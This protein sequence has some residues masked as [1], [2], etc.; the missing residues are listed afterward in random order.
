MIDVSYV[1]EVIFV[2]MS[3]FKFSDSKFLVC[4]FFIRGFSFIIVYF[5]NPCLLFYV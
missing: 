5:A 3:K 1:C 2:V 4:F